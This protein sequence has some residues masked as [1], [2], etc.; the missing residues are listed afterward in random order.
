[1]EN[2]DTIAVVSSEAPQAIGPYSQALRVG[3]WL[4]LSGQIPLDPKNGQ[5]LEGDIAQ[6]T[7]QVM[8]N[9][10]E[11]LI[12]SGAGFEHLVK[13][14]LYLV[15]LADFD[16]VNQV[17]GRYLHSPYPARSTVGVKELPKGAKIE[18]E[19]VARLPE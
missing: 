6:Q 14:T 8:N 12:A 17:Y 2:N 11:V 10:K 5:L 7:E 18:I 9:I 4:F 1:M 13:T 19:A 3:N 15:D 16:V